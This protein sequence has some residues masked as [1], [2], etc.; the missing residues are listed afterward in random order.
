MTP[1][2]THTDPPRRSRRTTAGS[3][4]AL[5]AVLLT[6]GG[7]FG[8]VACGGDDEPTSRAAGVGAREPAQATDAGQDRR[9]VGKLEGTDANIA[10]T[11]GEDVAHAYVCDSKRIWGLLSGSVRDGGLKLASKT[12]QA[13]VGSVAGEAVT[14]TVTL[15]DGTK[16]SFTASPAKG[17]A[18]LYQLTKEVD[19]TRYVTR[20]VKANDGSVRGKTTTQ[21]TS[22]PADAETSVGATDGAGSESVPPDA[23]QPEARGLLDGFRCNRAKSKYNKLVK[24]LNDRG[25]AS[26]AT[27]EEINTVIHL[28]NEVDKHCGFGTEQS[29]AVGTLQP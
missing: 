27:I 13:L 14:G 15:K 9:F 12:G 10:V 7:A 25:G 1:R 3:V 26:A 11:V 18:G 6:S 16:R 17:D 8:L 21:L 23:S 28:G 4:I 2:R 22:Q 19:G 29:D 5:A 24:Q 20:W